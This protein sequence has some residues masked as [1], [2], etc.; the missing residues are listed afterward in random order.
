MEDDVVLAVRPRVQLADAAQVD[1]GRAV[2]ADE[3]LRVELR[4]EVREG[5]A[6]QV[7]LLPGVNLDVVALG[8]IS[9]L[10]G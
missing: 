4:F 7:R 5:L 6:Q 3:L 9:R 1:D 2:D 10:T 8:L